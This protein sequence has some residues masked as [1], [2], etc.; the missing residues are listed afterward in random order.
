MKSKPLKRTLVLAALTL[1]SGTFLVGCQTPNAH[2]QAE[3]TGEGIA[4]FRADVLNGKKAID[5]TMASL[6]N[7]AT[8]ASTDP[9]K[10]FENYS[11]NVDN[12]ESTAAKIRKR[13]QDMKDQGQ[14]YFDQWQKELAEV[15]DPRIQ[16]M[17][18]KSRA[19]LTAAFDNIRDVTEP[20]KAQFDPWM[21]DLKDLRTY[22]SSDLTVNG[23]DAIKSQFKKT[24]S[25]GREVQKSMDALVE[26]LNSISAALNAAKEATPIPEAKK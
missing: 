16:Y 26:E 7:V 23:I 8:T 24:R 10:A 5:S 13:G 6:D 19:K 15:K 12:L 11:K 9:R 4:S 21:S 20:L 2:Q 22:L 3:K 18:K 25:S 1:G 17:A 14:A